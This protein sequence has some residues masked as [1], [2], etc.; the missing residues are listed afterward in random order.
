[1]SIFLDQEG[2]NANNQSICLRDFWC[3]NALFYAGS[4]TR[5]LR[6][7][8]FLFASPAKSARCSVGALVSLFGCRLRYV[9]GDGWVV[10]IV[11]WDQVTYM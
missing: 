5:N 11:S 10:Q 1:M 2:K 8:S 6:L 3:V 9:V 7:F 4:F